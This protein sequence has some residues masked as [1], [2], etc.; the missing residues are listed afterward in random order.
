MPTTSPSR[1]VSLESSANVINSRSLLLLCAWGTAA[2]LAV[3]AAVAAGRTELGD[4]R[5]RAAMDAILSPPQSPDR[6][7]SGQISTLSGQFDKEMRRQADMIHTL[8]EQR[9]GL[10]DRVGR[11][12]RQ[13]NELGATLAQTTARLEGETRSAQQAAAAASAVAAS[14]R[15]VPGKSDSPEGPPPAAVATAAQ[16]ATPSAASSPG[17]MSALQQAPLPPGQIHPAASF[18]AGFSAMSGGAPPEQVYTGAI[19][20]QAAAD[21]SSAPAAARPTHVQPPQTAAS[22]PWAAA[23][24][25]RHPAKASPPALPGAPAIFRSNPLMT[26]GIFATPAEPEAVAAEFAIDL[27]AAATIE[28]LRTRWNEL[29]VSQSPL[30]DN[31]KPLIALKDG[32]KSG[33]ELHLVAG[34]LTSSSAALRLCVVLVGTDALCQPTLYEGQRLAAR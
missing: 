16:A 6:Q 23:P 31:L 25:R 34:P 4:L 28:D 1:A 29:R 8:T 14:N 11:L 26:A 17:R 32:A 15:V 3:V 2:A 19:A 22:D 13:L 7:L 18:A 33:Q 24:P 27:G 9:N 10:L 12:E 20:P 30:L 5:L 21:T